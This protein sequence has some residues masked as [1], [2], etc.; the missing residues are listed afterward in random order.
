MID[1]LLLATRRCDRHCIMR[2]I[3]INAVVVA[4]TTM[5]TMIDNDGEAVI[6]LLIFC[7]DDGER[8]IDRSL[9]ASMICGCHLI[10]CICSRSFLLIRSGLQAADD[11]YRWS[12]TLVD[13]ML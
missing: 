2:A 9:L 4:T 11:L 5:P 12:F 8:C 7:S 3:T 6:I 10:V 1:A 13:R